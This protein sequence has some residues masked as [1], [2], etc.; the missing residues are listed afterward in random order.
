MTKRKKKEKLKKN[1]KELNSWGKCKLSR[2]ASK[3][4]LEQINKIHRKETC[5]NVKIRKHKKNGQ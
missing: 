2:I 1:C 3:I 5:W 4:V